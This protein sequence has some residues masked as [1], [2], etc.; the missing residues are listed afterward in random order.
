MGPVTRLQ[1]HFK[2]AG[3]D[4]DTRFPIFSFPRAG[5]PD[6][7]PVDDVLPAESLEIDID[8]LVE[9]ESNGNPLLSP[10]H[11]EDEPTAAGAIKRQADDFPIVKTRAAAEKRRDFRPSGNVLKRLLGLGISRF[12][13]SSK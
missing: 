9:M 12:A 7:Q 13:A 3:F 4:P 5:P 11:I 1:H 10:R 8:P 6:D 2:I